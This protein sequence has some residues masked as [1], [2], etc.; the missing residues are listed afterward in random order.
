[1]NRKSIY[2]LSLGC[3][4]NLV[5][6]EVLSALLSGSGLHITDRPDRADTIVVN[7]C[8]FILPAREESIEEILRMAAWKKKGRCRSLVVAGCLPQRY[9]AELARELPEVDLFLGT[10]DFPEILAHLK[11]LDE[12]KRKGPLL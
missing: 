3:P 11:R 12:G 10:G 5:D 1:M 9:G 6:S 7:T 8:A 4:K 2:I